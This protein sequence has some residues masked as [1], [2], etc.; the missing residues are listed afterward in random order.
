LAHVG[1]GFRTPVV[2]RDDQYP[3]RQ[4]SG[5]EYAIWKL[6]HD[7]SFRQ[8]LLDNEDVV[9][10]LTLPG[11]VN[12]NT[13]TVQ[14]VCVSKQVTGGGGGGEGGV[15]T[16]PWAVWANSQ[17]ANNT[18]KNSGS[19]HVIRG[20]VHSNNTIQISGAGNKSKHG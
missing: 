18:V 1:S 10:S 17:T 20:G 5:I 8:T 9:Q 19:G 2:A 11:D 7:S 13:P 6:T 16:L 3:V 14:A 12:G 4:R 15:S